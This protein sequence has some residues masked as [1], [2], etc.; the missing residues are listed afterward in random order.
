MFHIRRHITT[1]LG[2]CVNPPCL[3]LSSLVKLSDEG[4]RAYDLFV[5]IGVCTI[6]LAHHLGSWLRMS[7]FVWSIP[8]DFVFI[9]ADNE[10]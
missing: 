8:V 1:L 10:K 9:L 6:H 2:L 7:R 3:G 4:R 5:E